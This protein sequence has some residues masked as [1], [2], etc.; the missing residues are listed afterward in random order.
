MTDHIKSIRV[1]VPYSIVE[2]YTFTLKL[3]SSACVCTLFLLF[4]STLVRKHYKKPIRGLPEIVICNRNRQIHPAPG[5][6]EAKLDSACSRLGLRHVF[7]LSPSPNSCGQR[8]RDGYS[9]SAADAVKLI[10]LCR[11]RGQ[12]FLSSRCSPGF[13]RVTARL[14]SS[15]SS[16]ETQKEDIVTTSTNWQRKSGTNDEPRRIVK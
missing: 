9:R 4:W 2:K 14:P 6:R 11:L 1:W 10:T 7:L 13:R 5:S 8:L 15:L 3:Y 12:L 16:A